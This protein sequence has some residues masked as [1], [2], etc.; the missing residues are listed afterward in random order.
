[1]NTRDIDASITELVASNIRATSAPFNAA[2]ARYTVIRDGRCLNL[3]VAELTRD[4]LTL[5]AVISGFAG[6][7]SGAVAELMEA[8]Q[9]PLLRA[10]LPEIV[11][12][13]IGSL[14]AGVRR[15]RTIREVK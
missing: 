1:M 6:A 13:V 8:Q 14:D 5:I 4:E 11:C 12:Q 15:T 2:T 3:P 10:L 9:Y 7:T